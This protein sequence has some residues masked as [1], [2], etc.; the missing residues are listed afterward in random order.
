MGN[1]LGLQQSHCSVLQMLWWIFKVSVTR[2]QTAAINWS[3]HASNHLSSIH[4]EYRCPIEF[5]RKWV[6]G[7]LWEKG[8]IFLLFF[9]KRM[10][11]SVWNCML[12]KTARVEKGLWI[13]MAVLNIAIWRRILCKRECSSDDQNGRRKVREQFCTWTASSQRRPRGERGESPLVPFSARPTLPRSVHD[14]TGENSQSNL[15]GRSWIPE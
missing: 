13:S 1:P 6:R 8:M 9:R 14:C 5:M 3:L 12:F 11:I 7:E 10:R 2:C 4:G 15:L